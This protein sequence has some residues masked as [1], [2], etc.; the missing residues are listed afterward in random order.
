[1]HAAQASS[2]ILISYLYAS[3]ATAFPV[4]E[5]QGPP[6]FPACFR[7]KSN[8]GVPGLHFS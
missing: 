5:M 6:H 3:P 2:R 4:T 8:A 7:K 1:M